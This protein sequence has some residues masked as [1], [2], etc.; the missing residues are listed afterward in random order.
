MAS[1]IASHP[2][3][4]AGGPPLVGITTDVVEVAGPPGQ[5][6]RLRAV[7][8][9][10]YFNAVAD[11]GGVPVLLAPRADMAAA[12]VARCDAVVMTGGD[13]VR[14]EPLGGVTHPAA[15]PM[16][17]LRQAY[18]FALLA[19]LEAQRRKP[20]LGICLGMQLMT[21]HAGGEL[22]QHLPDSLPEAERHQR[23]A[24]H[25]I[26]PSSP[27]IAAGLATSSHH[28]GMTSAGRLTVL[29]TSDDG[30]IEAVHDP[31]RQFYLGVQWHPERTHDERLGIDL[32]RRLVA[33]ARQG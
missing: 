16:H 25:A 17:P 10:A 31:S 32:F 33:A 9:A 22:N 30:V 20:T 19:A 28:Q 5:P 27:L 11:A 6:P 24:V 4:S 2:P 14:M 29:A 8:A 26:R 12:Q 3:Q 1:P 15:K 23:D 18:E 21:V 7:S 13:D